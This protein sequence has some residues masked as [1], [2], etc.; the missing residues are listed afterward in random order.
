MT[1]KHSHKAQTP[2]TPKELSQRMEPQNKFS[3]IL[4]VRHCTNIRDLNIYKVR[5]PS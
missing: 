4:A 5:P 2:I 3:Y 1:L